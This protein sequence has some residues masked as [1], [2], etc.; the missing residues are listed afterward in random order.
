MLDFDRL[1]R[2]DVIAIHYVRWIIV[3]ECTR[4]RGSRAFQCLASSPRPGEPGRY[5]ARRTP[6]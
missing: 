4:S 5:V 1:N 2:Y 6:T 3:V